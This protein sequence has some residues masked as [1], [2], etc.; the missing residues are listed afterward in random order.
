M[1]G[2]G[3]W[4]H[5][6]EVSFCYSS[7]LVFLCCSLL[8]TAPLLQCG[9]PMGCS[10]SEALLWCELPM[11][12]KSL[13]DVPAPACRDGTRWLMAS[14][15]T[16]HPAALATETLPFMSNTTVQAI[17]KCFITWCNLITSFFWRKRKG[18]HKLGLYC[19]PEHWC[20]ENIINQ[21]SQ[22]KPICWVKLKSVYIICFST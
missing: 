9:W 1:D 19:I 3:S 14:S 20:F 16:E 4:G 10:P 7:L 22:A 2:A 21:T 17:F 6:I 8:L 11:G 18:N 13:R 15:H 12:C 5:R